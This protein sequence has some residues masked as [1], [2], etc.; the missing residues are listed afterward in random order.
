MSETLESLNNKLN[1]LAKSIQ[2]ALNQRQGYLDKADEIKKVYNRLLQDKKTIKGYRKDVSSFYKQKYSDFIG[3]N[4]KNVYKPTVKDLLD[5]YD[6]VIAN[7]D[8]NLDALNNKV[9]YYSNQAS[10][11]LGPIGS[12]ES[13]YNSVK[14]QIQNWTN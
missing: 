9:L 7:I 10:G 8:T 5:S 12:L 13:A 2:S 3:D 14:T 6:K 4:Y 11:C 1:K